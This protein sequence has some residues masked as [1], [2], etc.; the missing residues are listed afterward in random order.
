M[1]T[2]DLDTIAAVATPMGSGGI[3]IVRISGPKAVDISKQLFQ[4][5]H[6]KS[7]RDP[8]APKRALKSHVMYLGNIVDEE[9]KR[10]IDQVLMVI[11]YAPNSYTREN[12][13]E[14][15]CHGGPVIL[16]AIL[17]LVFKCGARSAAPGEFTKRAYINGR[18]DLSQ[19]E[20][21][22]DMINAKTDLALNFATDQL[23]GGLQKKANRIIEELKQI[24]AC[25]EAGINF[26]EDID[27][28]ECNGKIAEQLKSTCL[29][30]LVSLAKSYDSGCLLRDGVNLAIVGRPN[31]G[32]SSLFNKLIDAEKAIVTPYPGTT[33]DTV[34]AVYSING[35]PFQFI[36][37]AG[38]H[39]TNHPIERIGINRTRDVLSKAHLVLLVLEATQPFSA[40]DTEILSRIENKKCICAINKID[41]V[42]ERYVNERNEFWKD[43]TIIDTSA[44]TGYGIEK[45]KKSI[46]DECFRDPNYRTDSTIVSNIRHKFAI[47][48]AADKVR[49]AMDVI[50][51]YSN[52]ELAI[53]DLND[54]IKALERILGKRIDTDVLD[55]IFNKFCIG[56]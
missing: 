5:A 27:E 43:I 3:G 15:H 46:A 44:K 19:A 17:Q 38:L 41:L 50:S 48:E 47:E 24:I 34:E 6:R 30:S 22:A 39:D 25:M 54:A 20:A 35:I 10:V 31:V 42:K 9:Q 13:V 29:D 18:I 11:M 7:D 56:K 37:T 26:P 55:V 52:E 36:D 14:I 32:K 51:G 49:D 28:N 16:R 53:I 40:E 23:I 4:A 33:R 8:K 45:L 12:V 21:V 1:F 2:S